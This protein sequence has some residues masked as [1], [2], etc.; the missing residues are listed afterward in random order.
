MKLKGILYTI[1]AVSLWSCGEDKPKIKEEPMAVTAPVN[2]TCSPGCSNLEVSYKLPDDACQ[3]D[4]K[5]AN[6]FA[7]NSFL[8]LNWKAAGVDVPDSTAT[9]A[10]FGNPGDTSKTVWESF[11]SAEQIFN[12][13]TTKQTKLSLFKAPKTLSKLSKTEDKLHMLH[14][15]AVKA[16][17]GE[18][19]QELFQ[20][21]GTWLTDQQGE[22]VWYEVRTNVVESDFIQQNGLY[23]VSALAAY[24]QA[25]GG[26]WLPENAIEIKAAWKVVKPEQLDSLQQFYKIS[27]G[28][29]PQ[30]KGFDS[31]KQPIYGAYEQAYLALVGLHII[32]KTNLA[33]QLVWMTF[34]HVHNAPTV[35][36]INDTVSYSFF[37]KASTTKPNVS[38]VVGKDCLTTPVQVMRIQTNALSPEVKN[39]NEVA[40]DLIVSDNPDSV[41]QYYQLVNVQWP[42]S[43]VNDNSNNKTVPL[44]MGGIT[45]HNIANTT[46]ETY[47]QTF[48][49][50]DCHSYGSK[51]YVNSKKDTITI[52]TG[53]SFIFKSA[54]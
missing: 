31:N 17:A 8:A 3:L 40:Y 21:A 43:P 39:I 5:C 46:M 50:M 49:C 38:P 20:A 7:W 4:Q 12:P 9:A 26:V 47:A 25:N 11:L 51:S 42:E 53:Y 34:E 45:P 23:K 10:E 18:E 24:A 1:T 48:Q 13:T 19:L 27:K 6:A 15:A 41:W 2:Y 28:M 44:Q 22:L 29:V 32:R 30:I 33:P 16:A 14:S 35:G 37:N 52:P 54:Q 36:A